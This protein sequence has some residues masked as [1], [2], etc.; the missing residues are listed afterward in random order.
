M[1][2]S[3]RIGAREWHAICCGASLVWC[4]RECI[5]DERTNRPATLQVRGGDPHMAAKKKAAKKKG[6]K[7]KAAKKKK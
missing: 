1:N 3:G 7:K 2:D 4:T 5:A 6:T